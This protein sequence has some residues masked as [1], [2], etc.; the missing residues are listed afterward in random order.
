MNKNQ[1]T[2]LLYF[3]RAR[4]GDGGG[5]REE[6]TPKRDKQQNGRN[7]RAEKSNKN[8]NCRM[9]NGAKLNGNQF[10]CESLNK[11]KRT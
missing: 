2:I 4:E 6:A 7:R 8:R 5:E 1:F 9:R 10:A 11:L 3:P